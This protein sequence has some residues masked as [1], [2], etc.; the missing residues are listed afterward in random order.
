MN[1]GESTGDDDQPDWAH[2]NMVDPLQLTPMLRHYVELKSANPEKI[3]LYRLGDFFECFFED[4]IQLSHLL[5]L[6]LIG[7]EGGKAIGRLPM[8]GIPH[9]T[10]ERY[11][12]ELIRRG[13]CVAL[14]DQLETTAAKGALLKRGITRMLTPG[15]VIEEGMLAAHRN[16]WLAAVVVEPAQNGQYCQW[17]LASTDQM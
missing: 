4:A 17:G 3:L 8:A 16:N 9:H 15:T 13:L 2:Q 12:T 7:K 6:T 14:C 11:C 10:A 5:E 1:N